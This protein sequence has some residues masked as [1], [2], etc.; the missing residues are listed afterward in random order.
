MS[1]V[2]VDEGQVDGR[3]EAAALGYH[4]TSHTALVRSERPGRAHASQR[5]HRRASEQSSLDEV[6]SGRWGHLRSAGA[7]GDLRV[8]RVPTTRGARQGSQDRCGPSSA[9]PTKATT[10][11]SACPTT[12]AHNRLVRCQ[13]LA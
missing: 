3:Q 1:L 6:A 7:P 13:Y 9:Y 8:A 10:S 4:R 5:R 2:A 11:M 12:R